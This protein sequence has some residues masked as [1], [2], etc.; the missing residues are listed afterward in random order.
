MP[1]SKESTI[2]PIANVGRIDGQE[3]LSEAIAELN[4][5]LA[6]LVAAT[7]IWAPQCP[8]VT[9]AAFPNVR[10]ARG[11]ERR[12]QIAE[13]DRLDD[14]TYANVTIKRAL[15]HAGSFVGFATCH[16]WPN[17]CYDKRHHTVLANLI[18]VPQALA[19]LTDHD[20]HVVNCLKYRSWELYEWKP[21]GEQAPEK[22]EGYPT[23]WQEPVAPQARRR[24]RIRDDQ[25]AAVTHRQEVL[26]IELLPA[27]V[28]EFR[29]AFIAR[30][31]ATIEVRYHNRPAETRLWERQHLAENS[32]VISNLRSRPE[33]RQGTWQDLGISSVLVRV[34]ER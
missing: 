33:F 32:N 29:T 14:N 8:D 25:C 26:P 10:R 18:L 22:P 31:I 19:S 11:G 20:P 23:N 6:K 7:A 17:S 12:G 4:I 27:N 13:G 9:R 24:I 21:E 2:M 1:V 34:A 28:D 15:R 16:V 30:G 5:D 3:V